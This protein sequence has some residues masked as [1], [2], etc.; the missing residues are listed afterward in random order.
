MWLGAL[1]TLDGVIR[2][3]AEFR[4]GEVG[5]EVYNGGAPGG[6]SVG[7]RISSTVGPP[8]PALSS[9]PPPSA[10]SLLVHSDIVVTTSVSE[11]FWRGGGSGYIWPS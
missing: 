1:Q 3:K 5:V 9:S 10:S 2:D 4:D 11:I 7:G 6:E 8:A